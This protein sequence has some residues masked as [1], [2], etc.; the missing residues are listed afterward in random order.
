ML[1]RNALKGQLSLPCGHWTLPQ[2]RY[3]FEL[4]GPT[5][6]LQHKLQLAL[7]SYKAL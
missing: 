7:V 6:C 1:V 4:T 5:T 2:C 3:W